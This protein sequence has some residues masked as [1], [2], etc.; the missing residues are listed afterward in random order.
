VNNR[1][2]RA[3]FWA[4]RVLGLLFALFIS[5][6]AFDVFG[7]GY[8]FWETLVALFM[9][10]IPTWLVLIA[11]AVAWRWPWAGAVLFAAL[12]LAYIVIAPDRVDAIAY[13]LISGPL[14]LVAALFLADWFSGR[15]LQPGT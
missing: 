9:H 13:L 15:A 14:F 12:G 6:F 8:T 3:L 5:L 7:Q 1:L 10:L 11:L 2:K 4:P